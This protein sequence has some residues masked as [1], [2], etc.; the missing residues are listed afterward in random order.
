MSRYLALVPLLVSLLAT[1]PEVSAQN[2]DIRGTVTDVDESGGTGPTIT[3]AAE[4][5]VAENATSGSN[6]P[7]PP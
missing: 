6:L 5:S 1:P 7:R 2:A 3:S 4:H